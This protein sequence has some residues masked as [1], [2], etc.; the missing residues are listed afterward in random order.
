MSAAREEAVKAIPTEYGFF[1]ARARVEAFVRELEN[2]GFI[3]VPEWGRT[4]TDE[5]IDELL[6]EWGIDS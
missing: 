4:K 2:W 1:D 3:V 6:E 5:E